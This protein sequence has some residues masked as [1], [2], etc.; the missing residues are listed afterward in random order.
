[1]SNCSIVAK[2]WAL[3]LPNSRCVPLAQVT[4]SDNQELLVFQLDRF[5]GQYSSAKIDLQ[6]EFP[7]DLDMSPYMTHHLRQGQSGQSLSL[8]GMQQQPLP[9]QQQQLLPQPPSLLPQQKPQLQTFTALMR[10][11]AYKLYSV[12]VHT[13]DS[14]QDGNYVVFLRTNGHWLCEKGDSLEHPVSAAHVHLQRAYMLF[15]KR[16]ALEQSV[17]IPIEVRVTT[18]LVDCTKPPKFLPLNYCEM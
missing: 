10:S 17:A 5:D 1:M 9:Q 6:I 15:Y 7:D 18:N 11:S 16:V 2:P 4:F 8:G 3:I 14:L 13:G 12:L